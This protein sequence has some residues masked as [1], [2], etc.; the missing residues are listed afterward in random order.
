MEN[1]FDKLTTI[2]D[3]ENNYT[4]SYT[5]TPVFFSERAIP[6]IIQLFENINK[7]FM[8]LSEKEVRAIYEQNKQEIELYKKMAHTSTDNK[9]KIE[10]LEAMNVYLMENNTL[11]K[12][13]NIP[14]NEPE[15][16]ETQL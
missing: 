5:G 15:T 1:L 16:K 12:L 4:S 2:L 10:Y 8:R 6:Q 9:R 11:C 3:D 7:S 13:F 14:K